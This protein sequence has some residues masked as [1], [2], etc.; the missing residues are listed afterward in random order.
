MIQRE[1]DAAVLACVY[2][3][4]VIRA[5]A[6]P[7]SAPGGSQVANVGFNGRGRSRGA[8]NGGSNVG[9]FRGERWSRRVRCRVQARKPPG[10][11]LLPGHTRRNIRDL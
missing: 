10:N 5:P 1:G 11:K 3:E 9:G 6:E 8:G 7:L 2:L 4:L